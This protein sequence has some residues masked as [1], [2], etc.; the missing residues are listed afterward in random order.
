MRYTAGVNNGFYSKRHTEETRRKMSEAAK[1]N[2]VAKRPGGYKMLIAAV[3]NQA[4][5]DRAIWFFETPT[6]MDYCAVVGVDPNSFKR[7]IV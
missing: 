5:K 2:Q 3:I 6:G 4:A 7:G 1:G